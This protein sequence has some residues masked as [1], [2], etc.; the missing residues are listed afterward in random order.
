MAQTWS[1]DAIRRLLDADTCPRCDVDALH[2]RRCLNCGADL[3]GEIA[4]QLWTASVAAADALRARQNVL[5]LVPVSPVPAA[6]PT[7]VPAAQGDRD[8][9]AASSADLAPAAA[10]VAPSAALPSGTVPVASGPAPVAPERSSITVQSV[11]AVAGAGL[12]AIAA[13]VFT[14]LNPELTD[15]T[16]RSLIVGGVTIV[17]LGGAWVLARR[18]LQFS[19]EA[20]G[21]LGMVFVAL[22]VYAISE[23]AQPPVSAWL[24]SALGT[25]V[26]A[27]AMIAFARLARI[28]SWLFLGVLGLAVVP[29][30]IGYAVADGGDGSWGALLGHLGVAFAVIAVTEGL[31][32][33]APRFGGR[34]EAERVA[35]LVLQLLA[36]VVVLGQLR[37]TSAPT[38][39]AHWLGIAGVLAALA[40]VALLSTRHLIAPVWSFLAGGL[41]VAAISV[42]PF[43][44]D[45]ATPAWYLALV[46]AAAALALVALAVAPT[47]RSVVRPVLTAGVLALAAV[48]T[49]TTVLAGVA[50]V[51]VRI[52]TVGQWANGDELELLGLAEAQ[53]ATVVGLMATALGLGLYAVLGSRRAGGFP[54]GFRIAACAAVTVLMLGLLVFASWS[55]WL[56]ATQVAIA[57]AVA[58]VVAL[59]VLLIPAVRTS[60]LAI[61][62]PAIAGAHAAIVLGALMSWSDDDA[63]LPGGLSLTV[64]A[65]IVVVAVLIP[66]ALSIRTA[67][68]PIHVGAGYAYA[69]L[70]F[71]HALDLTDQFTTT[72]LLSI[73]TAVGAVVAIVA[74]LVPRVR[75]PAWYAVLIV[76]AVPFL[77]G[78]GIVVGDRSGWAALASG[79]IL[80]LALTLMLTRRPGLGIP[81]R[82]VASGL[83]VPTMAVVVTNLAAEYLPQ[84]G[85]PIALPVIAVIVAG[86]L[87]S[88]G[89]IRSALER[90]GLPE[91]EAAVARVWIEG[92]ALL[93]GA[94]AVLLALVRQAAGLDISFIVLVVLGLGALATAIWGGRRYAWWVAFGSFT[95]ALWCIWALQGVTTVEPYLLPPALA[96]ALIGV[97]V[98]ARGARGIPLYAVGLSAAVIPVLGILAAA[99][100]D[101]ADVPWR[102]YALLAGAWLLLLVGVLLGRGSRELL[103]RL[104]V[105]RL[106][107]LAVSIAAGAA[108]AIQGVRLGIGA[109]DLEA[110]GFGRLLL[111]LAFGT[112]GAIAAAAAARVVRDHAGEDSRLARTRW[113]YAPATA[114]VA[115]AAVT[116]LPGSW[117]EIWTHWA[118]MLAYL[119]FVIVLVLRARR[120]PTTLPPV[121]FVWG[122]AF[123]IAIVGWSAR[124]LRVEVFSVP[125]G[126]FLL[127]A[128]VLAMRGVADDARPAAASLTSWPIGFR[129]SWPL[130]GPGIVVLF[131][132][133]V[134]STATDPR[135]ERAIAVIVAA[136]LAILIGAQAKLRAP[137]ILGII[138]LPV[139]NVVA[140][141]SQLV[142]GQNSMPWWI[143]LAV[144]GA[145]LLIIAVTYERRSGADGSIAARMRDLR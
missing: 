130:L 135:I 83:L 29:A 88:T 86:V 127:A 133:S 100:S 53:P 76:T 138:V 49:I 119:G 124:E 21:A 82:A 3:R 55:A 95:G 16:L 19:A 17:F 7:S 115:I 113:L 99:G 40:I 94:L 69:L 57:L 5:D 4:E 34:L 70:I 27:V 8:V 125:L 51:L 60:S 73:T 52:V 112:A 24:F 104:A 128:G 6:V 47:P 72:A 77:I 89:L 10:V 101:D 121:W 1:D 41:A 103:R 136:L 122:I 107:T 11:L 42:L 68:H 81:L 61:R 91:R 25:L 120:A 87:P 22:D 145:V 44:L 33:V 46:P 13:I 140:F 134:L 31:R 117:P 116:H 26:S 97:I 2:E 39:T 66:V 74:T 18:A 141:A 58:L 98:T 79:L 123:V 37:G 114:Y 64:V 43:A 93:T 92:S 62:I 59:A 48:A 54:I 118:L 32:I 111:S 105:L 28:R 142:R 67:N 106:P 75:A 78:V 9:V 137:F 84:S 30:M 71:A 108:G 80:L 143:T 110:D 132:A 144:V 14:F 15:T 56:L 23:L 139:E 90:H 63:G 20:V 50:I 38:A 131:L 36:V 65:G 85:S 129:A 35:L 102:A 126:L 96:L 12:F 109:D 45:L